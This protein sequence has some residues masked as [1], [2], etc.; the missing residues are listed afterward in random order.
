M[1]QEDRGLRI[2]GGQGTS[3]VTLSK[4]S[5]YVTCN[6]TARARVETL[7]QPHTTNKN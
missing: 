7:R 3:E 2:G 5:E 6:T 1:R 4:L